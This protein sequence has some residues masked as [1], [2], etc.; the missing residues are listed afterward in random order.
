MH[1]GDFFKMQEQRE[2]VIEVKTLFIFLKYYLNK[3]SLFSCLEY[4]DI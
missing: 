2:I 4:A 1:L 3:Y